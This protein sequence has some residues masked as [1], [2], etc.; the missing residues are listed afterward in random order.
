MTPTGRGWR[1][2]LFGLPVAV[3]VILVLVLG[4]EPAIPQ[5]IAFNHFKHTTELQLDCSFCHQYV[6]DGAHAGL[7]GNEIC[8]ICHSTPQGESEEAARVTELLNAGTPFRFNKLFRLPDHVYYTHRRHA[9]A[10][11]LD[12][13]NCHGDIADTERPPVRPLVRVDMDFC[14]DCHEAS[15]QT[16]DCNACHR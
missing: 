2:L 5:P 15:G 3:F 12:C 13:A 11:E 14:I 16:L 9:G 7:P 1:G 4:R 10:G 8:A 6:N